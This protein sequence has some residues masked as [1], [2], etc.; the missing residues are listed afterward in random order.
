[1]KKVLLV[2]YFT[3]RDLAAVAVGS[4]FWAVLNVL[5]SPIFWEL[6]R[7]PFLCDLLAFLS[8][9]VVVW[10]TGKLGT[11]SLT[12]LV[13]TAMTLVLRP[14]AFHILGFAAASALFDVATKGIGYSN[15]FE[16]ATRSVVCIVSLSLLSAGVAGAIIGTLFMGFKTMP[17]ILTFSGLHAI[18]GGIGGM[19]GVTV[20]RA[21]IARKI[22]PTKWTGA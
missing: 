10:W 15:C 11:A 3:T 6:T 1:M 2:P 22:Q 4:S 18:G 17:A 9:T 12:G 21:L 5:I 8:L 7:M 14:G 19:M 16:K 13:V 20:V